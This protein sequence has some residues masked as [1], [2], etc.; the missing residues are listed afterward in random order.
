MAVLS[1]GCA[2]RGEEGDAAIG[3]I[4]LYGHC[5][6]CKTDFSH[7]VRHI[8]IRAAFLGQYGQAFA[9]VY[10]AVRDLGYTNDFRTHHLEADCA[11][12]CLNK[13]LVLMAGS[14]KSEDKDYG[15]K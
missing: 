7:G 5:L 1:Q 8:E 11:A 2:V 3:L 6:C 15:Y 10:L 12:T 9:V 14:R 13:N 4:N